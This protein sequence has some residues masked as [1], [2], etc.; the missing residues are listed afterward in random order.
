[1]HLRT[2]ASLIAVVVISLAAFASAC[3]GRVAVGPLGA[4]YEYEEDLTLSLDGSATLVVN[5][6]IPALV[7]LRGLPL[8]TDLRTR[9]DQ[10]KEQLRS[11]YSS[12]H[13][14]VGRISNWTRGGRRFVGI[15]V[16]VIDIRRLPAVAPFSWSAYDLH[17]EGDQVVFRQRL[18]PA[19][20]PGAVAAAGLTGDEL[21][22]FRL[23]LPARIRFQNARYLDRDESR[24]TARG[25]IVTWE[26]RLRER[27]LGK[28]IA[29]A[30]DRT[31]DVMEVRM[32][33]TSILYRTLWLFAIAF[34]AALLVIAGLIWLTVRRGRRTG[35]PRPASTTVP[36]SPESSSH[37]H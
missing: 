20:P 23:H 11:L 19:S 25:N 2:R 17:E 6:S 32:D 4:S 10:L 24:P 30:E 13:S 35:D 34:A 12:E 37:P 8:N 29:Y 22:A 5:A 3:G 36:S 27:A 1:M 14:R 15:H 9:V 18:K 26:Q 28:P 7:A 16:T 31:P 33:R 21:I